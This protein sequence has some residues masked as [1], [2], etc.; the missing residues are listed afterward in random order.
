MA[1]SIRADNPDAIAFYQ[2]QGFT[3]VGIARRQALVRDRYVD[4]VLAER[5][6]D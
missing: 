2:A 1:R 6:L 4:E 3:V 5:L